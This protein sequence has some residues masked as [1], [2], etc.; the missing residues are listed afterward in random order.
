MAEMRTNGWAAGGDPW[1][2][3]GGEG[4]RRQGLRSS[5]GVWWRRLDGVTAGLVALAVWITVAALCGG[6]ASQDN[7]SEV[8]QTP[9]NNTPTQTK[10]DTA[11]AGSTYNVNNYNGD[12]ALGHRGSGSVIGAGDDEDGAVVLASAQD[13]AAG[14]SHVGQ[15]KASRLQVVNINI[16]GS[17]TTPSV[18]GSSVGT[19]T[20][21]SDAN[22]TASPTQTNRPESSNSLSAAAALPGGNANSKAT[23]TGRGTT[24]GDTQDATQ[25]A[26]QAESEAA[27]LRHDLGILRTRNAALRSQLAELLGAPDTQPAEELTPVDEMTAAEMRAEIK[28]LLKANKALRAQ[29]VQAK[30]EQAKKATTAPAEGG[31]Q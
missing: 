8:A 11:A 5:G 2:D 1:R 23:A 17:S 29:I 31:G 13:A 19:G 30:A 28:A 4:R 9:V 21:T 7:K 14:E 3:I 16:G 24:T 15:G 10:Q 26:T 20:Q 22:S 25:T 27:T 12:D 6:C 18:T